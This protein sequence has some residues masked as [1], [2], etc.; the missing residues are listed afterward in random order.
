MY[1]QKKLFAQKHISTEPFKSAA[2]EAENRDREKDEV[3][4]VMEI[5][6]DEN[7]SD[8]DSGLPV[9][10]E[11]HEGPSIY[12]NLSSDENSSD[13]SVSY[14]NDDLP[15]E[16]NEKRRKTTIESSSEE[17]DA[18]ESNKDR[19]DKEREQMIESDAEEEHTGDRGRTVYS[20]SQKISLRIFQKKTWNLLKMKW[21][22]SISHAQDPV[23]VTCFSPQPR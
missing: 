9:D 11:N 20:P 18:T 12:E 17:E 22:A 2:F 10:V 23:R 4:L 6:D 3:E 15:R 7:A 13:E 8:E 5:T 16:S 1:L 19:G 14:G 21:V